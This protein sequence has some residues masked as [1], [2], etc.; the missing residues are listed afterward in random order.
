MYME[1]TLPPTPSLQLDATALHHGPVGRAESL[2]GAILQPV[3][4]VAVGLDEARVDALALEGGVLVLH[5]VCGRDVGSVSEPEG[6][7]VQGK[8]VGDVG[9]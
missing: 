2:I 4:D 9:G 8:L 5:G 3:Q 7:G 6:A 1:T